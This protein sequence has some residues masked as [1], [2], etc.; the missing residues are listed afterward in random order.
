[1]RFFVVVQL[2]RLSSFDHKTLD[3]QWSLESSQIWDDY[4][5]CVYTFAL[6]SMTLVM[7]DLLLSLLLF[8]LHNTRRKKVVVLGTSCIDG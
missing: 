6:M 4:I 3:Y 7:K 1:M 2:V 8:Y 5:C